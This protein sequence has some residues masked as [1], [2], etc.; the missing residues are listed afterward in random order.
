[1]AFNLLDYADKISKMFS[2]LGSLCPVYER[3]E[4]LFPKS[5]ELREA[6]FKFYITVVNFCRKVA[7]FAREASKLHCENENI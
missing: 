2:Q 5:V 3:F 4:K 7:T 1:M 6:I